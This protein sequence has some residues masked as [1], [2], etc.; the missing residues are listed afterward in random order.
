MAELLCRES[1]E[2]LEDG[3]DSVDDCLDIKRPPPLDEWPPG[4]FCVWFNGVDG[5]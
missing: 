5:G 3:P 2:G 4:C 1:P